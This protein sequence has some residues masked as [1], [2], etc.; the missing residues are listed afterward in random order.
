MNRKK[1]ACCFGA[2]LMMPQT[3]LAFVD[4]QEHWAKDP[5]A[6][7]KGKQIISGYPDGT[8]RPDVSMQ[9]QEVATLV[10]RLT[11]QLA[12]G[13][14]ADA[15]IAFEDTDT[16]AKGFIDHVVTAGLMKG[17]GNGRFK[18]ENPLT[19]AEA[20]SVVYQLM[21]KAGMAP[22]SEEKDALFLDVAKEAW[23]YNAVQQMG[24]KKIL[25]GYGDGTFRPNEPV[26]RAEMVT[27]LIVVEH[28]MVLTGKETPVAVPPPREA[29]VTEAPEVEEP[30]V[31]E[32]L[33]PYQTHTP[34]I[35][36]STTSVRQMQRWARAMGAAQE[37]IDLAPLYE[38][39]ALQHGIDPAVIYT[40]SA[41]ETGYMNF[42]GAID[43]SWHNP[44]G[45]KTAVAQS[46][47]PLAHK[48]FKDW[49]EGITAMA[50]HLCLYA[51]VK[52]YPKKNSPDERQ[53]ASIKGKAKT[54]EELGAKWAPSPEYGTDIV[55]MMNTL[56]QY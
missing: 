28:A 55:R 21:T 11:Q 30:V 5:I 31:E 20:A 24:L 42:G 26:S 34:I 27:M 40:Q 14:D 44:C 16:W 25:S 54:V 45:L 39:I 7:M 19:R 29:P 49:D 23:Y 36:P 3:A 9:R 15:P 2:I 38:R 46:D 17:Y 1:M 47:E 53:F 35:G 12:L 43:A 18:P 32:T 22:I 13:S 48:I 6:Q 4:T 51:G 52:G 33:I 56:Y 37:F 8:Y 10:S 41:K 50:H